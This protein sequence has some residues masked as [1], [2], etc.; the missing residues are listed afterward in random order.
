MAKSKKIRQKKKKTLKKGRKIEALREAAFLGDPVALVNLGFCYL[1]GDGVTYN[2][3]R[4]FHY[5]LE[6]SKS[7]NRTAL[8]NVGICCLNGEGCQKDLQKAKD[9][10]ARSAA[11]G[12]GYAKEPLSYVESQI[13]EE[14]KL[15]EDFLKALQKA[16]SGDD[17]A[18]V[19]LGEYYIYG[20]GTR[21]NIAK[22]LKILKDLVKEENKDVI[23]CLTSIY[24]DEEGPLYSVDEA[25][26]FN[27]L[28]AKLGISECIHNVGADY[29]NS[30]Q[31]AKG[32]PL[33][34]QAAEMDN[35]LSNYMCAQYYYEGKGI[36]EDRDQVCKYLKKA[37]ELKYE[38]AYKWNRNLIN[39]NYFSYG[40]SLELARAALSR[41]SWHDYMLFLML[42]LKNK[43]HYPTALEFLKNL[44]D[45]GNHNASEFY[46][47]IKNYPDNP[48]QAFIDYAKN[49]DGQDALFLSDLYYQGALFP[50][51]LEQS[52]YWMSVAADRG[53]NLAKGLL[54]QMYLT[55]LGLKKDKE[56]GLS[57]LKEAADE[58]D[59][60]SIKIL[61]ESYRKGYIVPQSKKK[62]DHYARQAERL[63]KTN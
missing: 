3:E 18:Q 24:S 21:Q 19:L 7:G 56:K 60:H 59:I 12:Y 23:Y 25:H 15:Q 9:Y 13:T 37:L 50:K 2:P 49:G 55:G 27:Q 20:A 61:E 6:A 45:K 32:F 5:F 36:K 39:N 14:K 42:L 48:Q 8:Y 17:D 31:F 53:S 63:S 22:G 38:D 51:N 58:N 4:A 57:L 47:K 33:L 30:G 41:E 54:W 10:L 11:L 40:Q 35:P 52:A 28:G 29:I 26:Q 44:S 46:E 16:D 34:K 1:N 62:A 43:E